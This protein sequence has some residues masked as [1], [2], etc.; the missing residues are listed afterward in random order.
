MTATAAPTPIP[1][2]APADKPDESWVASAAAPVV[3]AMAVAGALL[4]SVD[5]QRISTPYAFTRPLVPLSVP[6]ATVVVVVGE[7]VV[8]IVVQKV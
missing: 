1:A 7:G 8:E 5:C 3:V 6:E 4:K 2:L